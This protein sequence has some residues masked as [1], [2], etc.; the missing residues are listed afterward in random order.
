VRVSQLDEKHDLQLDLATC[1]T[2]DSIFC[3]TVFEH[4]NQPL[5]TM[6]RFHRTLRSGGLLFFDYIAG[7]ADGLDT[8]QGQA[9]R[10]EVLRWA[11]ENFTLLHGE[12]NMEKTMGLTLIQKK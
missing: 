9:Q 11:Q 2:F 7:D 8:E 12:W 3:I 10:K 6:K 5:E 4:L 1:G